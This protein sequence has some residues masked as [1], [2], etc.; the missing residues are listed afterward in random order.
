[1]WSKYCKQYLPNLRTNK[2]KNKIREFRKK[3]TID[4][5]FLHVLRGDM[6]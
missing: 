5:H 4:W 3:Y 2:K 1:M 6:P